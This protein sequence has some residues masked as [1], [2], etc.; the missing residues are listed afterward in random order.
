M[1]RIE[2]TTEIRAPID[3]CFDL[4]RSI[5][6]H[7]ATAEASGE[8]AVAGVT[9]GLI[10]LGEQVTWRARHFGVA[11]HMTSLITAAVRPVSFQDRMIQ[12]PF[13]VFEHDHVFEEAGELTRMTDDLRFEAPA[14]PIGRI[15]SA[16]LILPHL[17]RFLIER[18]A[19]LK[20]VAESADEWKKYLPVEPPAVI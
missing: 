1:P 19:V 10:G 5:D 16:R 3:R 7:V 8:Q 12:G 15:V 6:L 9:S 2:L 11:W 4:G 14:G 13:A 18:N 20:R 17:T